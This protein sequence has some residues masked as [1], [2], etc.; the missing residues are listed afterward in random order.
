V[1]DRLQSAMSLRRPVFVFPVSDMR[2]YEP[3][4]GMSDFATNDGSLPGRGFVD[5][6]VRSGGSPPTQW[7]EETGT[8]NPRARGRTCLRDCIMM[9]PGSTV[10]DVY[11]AL[12]RLRAIDG[13]YVRAEAASALGGTPNLVTKK[14]AISYKNRIIHIMTTK[15]SAWQK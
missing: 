3:L 12:K 2:T 5:T 13:E 11:F 4:P 1:L 6:L 9:K 14:E 7:S 15:R 10:E 8:Y